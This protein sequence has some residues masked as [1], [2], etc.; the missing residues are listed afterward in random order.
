[1][2]VHTDLEYLRSGEGSAEIVR[3][4][5]LSQE[6]V[7]RIAC[8]ADVIVAVD[9]DVGHTMFEGRRRRYPSDAQRRE[10]WRRDRHCRFPGCPN[11]LFTQV[12]HIVPWNQGG[13]TDLPNL[14][15]LC[16]HHHHRVH[17]G[18]WQVGG[19]ANGELTFVGPSGRH[20]TSLPS[21]L[22]IRRDRAPAS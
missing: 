5:L 7:Q 9:D 13:P 21:E 22:W 6:T 19:D 10:V 4:G 20:M 16:N 17:E 11:A 18:A 14:A 12:H 15:L 3:L 1:V 2:V 8:E